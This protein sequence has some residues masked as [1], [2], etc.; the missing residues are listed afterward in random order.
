MIAGDQNADP[1]DGDS[2]PGAA[3]QLLT[4]PRVID[5]G[6]TSAG[7]AEAARL[8]GGANLTHAGDQHLDTADFND[9]A[10]GNLRVDY[11]LPARPMRVVGSGVFWPLADDE[12]ARLSAASDHHAVWADVRLR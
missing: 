6:P 7:G 11:V 1:V 5:P 3:Q 8:Q 2:V 9:E 10:P 4:A 12:L